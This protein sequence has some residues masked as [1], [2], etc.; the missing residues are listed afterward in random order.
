MK[1]IY[2]RRSIRS[3]T[4]RE[5]NDGDLIEIVK[6]GMNAPSAMNKKL[7]EFIVIKDKEI[8]AN[9]SNLAPTA[10]MLNKCNKAIVVIG[11][12]ES[13][14][15][16]QDLS[17][18]TQNILLM[19]TSLNIA[20]CWIGVYPELEKESYAKKV[21]NIPDEYMV[22]SVITL[23]YTDKEKDANNNFNKEKIHY[24]MF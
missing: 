24:D 15:L 1:E 11:K 3:Y 12:K 23:G 19:S 5:I 4:D 21:L 17:A 8:M 7:W 18:A 2:Q 20:S 6:A 10:F 13:K 22:L 14:Y 16:E 9:L